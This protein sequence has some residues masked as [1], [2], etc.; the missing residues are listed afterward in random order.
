MRHQRNVTALR[1][2]PEEEK[3]AVLFRIDPDLWVRLKVVAA[4]NRS[5]LQAVL[6]EAVEEYLNNNEG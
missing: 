1:K 2:K 3:K 4:L 6:T 5:T